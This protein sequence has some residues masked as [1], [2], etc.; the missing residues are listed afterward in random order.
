MVFWGHPELDGEIEVKIVHCVF[1][2]NAATTA[3]ALGVFAH[4][5]QPS[6]CCPFVLRA[7]GRHL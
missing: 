7:F 5:L 4:G 3:I 1:P 2:N 6:L